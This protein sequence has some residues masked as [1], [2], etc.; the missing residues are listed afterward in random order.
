VTPFEREMLRLRDLQRAV[1]AEK[2]LRKPRLHRCGYCGARTD[3]PLA[4]SA[5]SDLPELDSAEAAA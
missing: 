4:C 2:Q 1:R 5:H 3:N